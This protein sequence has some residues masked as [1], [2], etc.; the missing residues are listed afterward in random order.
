MRFLS[1]KNFENDTLYQKIRRAVMFISLLPTVVL[2]LILLPALFVQ[3]KEELEREADSSLMQDFDD[4]VAT[5]ADIEQEARL[6]ASD[7]RFF[8]EVTRVVT[9]NNVSEYE[10]ILFRSQTLPV[11][12]RAMSINGVRA[13]RMH[14]EYPLRREY[15]P[16][17]YR[18]DRA[19][20]SLWYSERNRVSVSGKWFFDVSG[21]T[22]EEVYSGYVTGNNMASFILP[23]K[24]TADIRG[25]LEV[26]VPIS[27][28]APGI[29]DEAEPEDRILIDSGGKQYGVD[30]EDNKEV[31]LEVLARITGV[32]SIEEYLSDG[33]ETSY[34]W[35][36]GRL[37]MLSLIRHSGN[38]IFMVRCQPVMKQYLS[39][40]LEIL[41]VIGIFYCIIRVLLWSIN[42]IVKR[43]LTDMDILVEYVK[44]VSTGELELRIPRLKQV[45][46]RTIAE[47]YNKMLDNLE[48]MTQESIERETILKDVQLKALEKQID[49][50]FLYNVLDS[51]K[52]MAEIREIFD[53][54][55]ALL[56]LGR[57]FRYNL[58]THT[59]NVELEEEIAYLESYIRLMNLRMD[60]EIKVYV[61][62]E[63]ESLKKSMVPKMIL[64]PLAENSIVHG[65]YGIKMDT[66][67]YLKL[68][69]EEGKIKI[70]MTDM[71][72]GMD[73]EKLKAVRAKIEDGG[74]EEGAGQ[75]G[76]Y[77][78]HRRLRLIYG[79][80][81]GVQI[82]SRA[83]CYTKTILLLKEGGSDSEKNTDC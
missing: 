78:I 64:Q 23:F 27:A 73:E 39:I 40:L 20:N 61:Q 36:N 52:M 51:I 48:K 11:L 45:E 72:K 25:I 81:C 66:T 56:A 47:E 68:S 34:L 42:R 63:D 37:I 79:G 21:S 44:S 41:A 49:S 22:K 59:K 32:D 6:I 28:L 62:M 17:L 1:L 74:G 54:A 7:S 46:S 82:Y 71:G 35:L 50:H 16:Y 43:M 14:I 26:M 12:Q 8:A 58:S 13:A 33:I 38:G 2:L 69:R 15:P 76:L 29:D 65:L 19:E 80:G 55:D 77:N 30:R 5:L 18:M 10:R 75:I 31:T 24:L 3:K 83:G 9:D 67:I 53:V 57:M 4:F 70:E 60:Y